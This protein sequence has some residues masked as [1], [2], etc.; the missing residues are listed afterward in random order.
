[1]IAACAARAQDF[2]A[3]MLLV[4]A[5]GV[6]GAYSRTALVVVPGTGGHA[7][8]ILNRSRDAKLASVLPGDPLSATS[9]APV[10]FGGPLG[11]KVVFAMVRHDPGE[12][13]KRLF[14]DVFMTTGAKTLERIVE[15][16]PQDARFFAGMVVW[17]PGELESEIESGDWIVTYPDAA[18]VF[19][20]DPEAMW[21][22]LIG[23]EGKTA[24]K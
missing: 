3:P 21:G 9:S 7:G 1:L 19:H 8:F 18:M 10:R 13:A 12:G 2:G 11:S 17:L 4:A 15:Q 20:R 22:E 6:Q 24:L 23:R 14:G 16:A 5:P